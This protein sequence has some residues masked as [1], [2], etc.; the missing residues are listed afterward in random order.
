MEQL[1]DLNGLGAK[2]RNALMRSAVRQHLEL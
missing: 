1:E 2:L